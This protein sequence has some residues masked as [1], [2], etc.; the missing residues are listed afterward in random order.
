M[1]K[2]LPPQ[3]NPMSDGTPVEQQF[4]SIGF[5]CGMLQKPPSFIVTLMEA[6]EV[7][8]CHTLDGVGMIRGDD[9]QKMASVLED[10]ANFKRSFAS[11]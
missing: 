7:K 3:E 1:S 10:K 2:Q 4:Y 9:L 6:A 11:N 8:F 5:V